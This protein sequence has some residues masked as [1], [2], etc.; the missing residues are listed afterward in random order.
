MNKLVNLQTLDSGGNDLTWLI[1]Q[2]IGSLV[3]LKTL[4]LNQNH[5]CFG[6]ICDA[7][8]LTGSIPPE[9]Q[10]LV[11]LQTLDLS[12][13]LLSGSLPSELNN[14][15]EVLKQLLLDGQ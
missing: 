3:N 12:A 4:V 6:W 11:N 5:H 10:N 15:V 14:L 1:R 9:I 7:N 2:E 13:N 8:G